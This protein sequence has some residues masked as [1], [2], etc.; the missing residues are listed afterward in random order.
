MSSRSSSDAGGLR[1]R[2]GRVAGHR[3]G[4]GELTVRVSA[5]EAL[6]WV[7]VEQVLVGRDEEDCATYQVEASRGYSDRLVLKLAGIDDA[8]AAADLKGKIVQVEES[9]AP[10]L[11][12]GRYYA[13][14]LVGMSVRDESH[15][16]LGFVRDLLPTAGIDLLVVGAKARDASLQGDDENEILIPFADEIVLDV[17][18]DAGEIRVRVPEGLVEL[19]AADEEP[20]A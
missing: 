5:G 14:T 2:V 9:S 7:G 12:E 15:G 4:K 20:S 10:Q 16:R 17:D 6:P 3:G 18:C 11:P 1:L 19:N 13:A 8:S